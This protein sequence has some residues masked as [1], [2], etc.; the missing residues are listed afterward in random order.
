VSAALLAVTNH[1]V[2]ELEA[3]HFEESRKFFAL[4]EEVKREIMMD[5]NLRCATAC[6]RLAHSGG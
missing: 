5:E 2:E 4:P 1:G 3:K 6:R